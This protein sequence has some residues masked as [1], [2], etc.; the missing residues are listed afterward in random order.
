MTKLI[1]VFALTL[2]I[3]VSAQVQ[4]KPLPKPG[5]EKR[6]RE[7]V[8]NMKVVDTHEHLGSLAINRDWR[9]KCQK[10]DFMYLFFIYNCDDLISAGLPEQIFNNKLMTDSMSVMEKWRTIKPYWEGCSNTAYNRAV[11]LAIDKLYGVKS[12]DSTTVVELSE[13][14]RKAYQDENRWNDRILKEKCRIEYIVEDD[15]YD[16]HDPIF[17]SGMFRFVNRFDDFIAVHSKGEIE[18]H[19]HW[20]GAD[21]HSLDD[22]VQALSKAFDAAKADGMIGIKS[23]LAYGR[24]ISY[25]NV[26]KERAEEVFNKIMNSTGQPI[27]FEEAKP[28]QDYMMHRMLDLAR[29][30]HFAVQIHTGLQGNNGNIIENSKPT[31]LV[32]LFQEYPGV[33]F[34]LFHGSYPYG[35][36]LSTLAKNFP[37]VYIDMC[38]S[39]IISPSYSERYLNEWMETVPANKIMAFGGDQATVEGTYGNLLFTRQVV[40]NV[41]IA[42]VRDGYFTEAEALKVAQMILHDNAVRI[43]NL[44]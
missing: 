17:K 3:S 8:D 37:N 4:I 13:K 31:R 25:E 19:G 36:E 11:L 20:L 29:D 32:N 5:Y 16:R 22:Y 6:I 2:T 23:A 39:F 38:W 12:I 26:G 40:S 1:I 35:G 15:W 24:I 21:I 27:T 33:K 30:N 9:Y 28:L 10:L 43:L 41:L 42:K 7:Y 14:I 18:S 34:C 44:K